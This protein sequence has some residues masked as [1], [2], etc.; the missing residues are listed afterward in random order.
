[1]I[2]YVLK[3]KGEYLQNFNT[4]KLDYLLRNINQLRSN[5]GK[6]IKRLTLQNTDN[7]WNK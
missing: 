6:S 3:I 4:L 5:L 2:F 1:M 7:D